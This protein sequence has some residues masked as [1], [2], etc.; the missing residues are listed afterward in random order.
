MTH[1]NGVAW[2]ES[3]TAFVHL[4]VHQSTLTVIFFSIYFYRQDLHSMLL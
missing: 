2:V 4:W 1:T 3:K